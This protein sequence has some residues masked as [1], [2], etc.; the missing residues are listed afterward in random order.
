MTA[1]SDG[2][3]I[4]PAETCLIL[5]AANQKVAGFQPAIDAVENTNVVD[6]DR[7]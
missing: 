2:D 5:R 4:D 6:D 1:P 7:A 3:V